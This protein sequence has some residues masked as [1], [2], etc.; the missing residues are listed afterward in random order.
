M[1]R[2]VLCSL[3]FT[4][5]ATS[6]P[7]AAE[8]PDP[9]LVTLNGAFRAAYARTRKEQLA[10]TDP[11]LL[12]AAGRL[13]LIHQGK[14]T[15]ADYM[16]K[17]YHELKAVSHIPLALYVMLLGKTDLD[18]EQVAA[19]AAYR[20]K[21]VAAEKT[22]KDRGFD[23]DLLDKQKKIVA[24]SLAFLDCV[25]K[26]RKVSAEELTRFGRDMGKQLEPLLAAAAQAQ[27]EALDAQVKVFRK[28]LSD[29][30]W[31]RLKVVVI[32]SAMPRKG[33]LAVQYFSRLLGEAGEG[34]RIIYAESLW[35]DEKALNL[36]GTHVLDGQIG[37]TFFNDDRRMMRDL[38]EDAARAYLEKHRP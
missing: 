28:D 38:L 17:R 19:L 16:P 5:V 32:G 4:V 34:P 35:D 1:R 29:A 21:I 10:A 12:E 7:R 15:E 27:L 9:L 36:L 30:D 33:H 37:A 6:A 23:A 26:N 24:D 3:I 2:A 31:K 11:V 20:D 18:D 25:S 13:V 22:L 14:R 8:P